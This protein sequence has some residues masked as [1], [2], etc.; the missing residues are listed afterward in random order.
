MTWM[1]VK[2]GGDDS[3]SG[4]EGESGGD[5]KKDGS[6]TSWLDPMVPCPNMVG[7]VKFQDVGFYPWVLDRTGLGFDWTMDHA[8]LP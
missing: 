8:Y 7:A 3:G 4:S 2:S 6:V 1:E 5:G